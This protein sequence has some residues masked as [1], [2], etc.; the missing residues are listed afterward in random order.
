MC[1][2]DVD[3]VAVITFVTDNKPCRLMHDTYSLLFGWLWFYVT[4]VDVNQ[5]GLTRNEPNSKRGFEAV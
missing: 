4:I 5:V 1:L 3:S 2:V